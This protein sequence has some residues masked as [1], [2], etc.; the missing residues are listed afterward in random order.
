[1]RTAH[2]VKDRTMSD[3]SKASTTTAATTN[4]KVSTVGIEDT[5]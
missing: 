3:D 1:M 5:T 2:A 4:V